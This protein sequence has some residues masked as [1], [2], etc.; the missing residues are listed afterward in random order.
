[1]H[2]PLTTILLLGVAVCGAQ[3]NPSST[4]YSEMAAMELLVCDLLRH[5]PVYQTLS[6]ETD[7]GYNIA[8]FG[9]DLCAVVLYLENLIFLYFHFKFTCSKM[10]ERAESSVK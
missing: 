3:P 10:G 6:L 1:M 9:S 5:H 7:C 8:K 4:F 2:L